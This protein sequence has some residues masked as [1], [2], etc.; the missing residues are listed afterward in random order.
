MKKLFV[1][2]TILC[3]GLSAFAE[4]FLLDCGDTLR[5]SQISERALR[6][7][8]VPKG[9]DGLSSAL[10]DKYFYN[11]GTKEC[12][13]APGHIKYVFD[14]E[15]NNISFYSDEGNL[16][17]E[18]V[19]VGGNSAV[20]VSPDETM[21]M[22]TGQF[23]DGNVNIK[24][25]TRRLTQ[26]NTQISVPMVVS[27]AGY[28]ILWNNCGM[29]EF[30]P[31]S[32]TLVLVD[33]GATGD[34]ET[35]N[36]T[37]TVG[38]IKEERHYGFFGGEIDVPETGEYAI[39]LDVGQ[40]MARKHN[41]SI[42][43]KIVMDA[44][45]LWLPPTNAAI[46]S[47]EKGK[48]NIVVKGEKNDKP[49][50]SYRKLD[51]TTAFRSENGVVDYTIIAGTPDEVIA[52]FRHLTGEVPMMPKWAFGYVHCRERFTSQNDLLENATEFRRRGIPIDMIVQDWQWWGNNGWN[53][54]KFDEVNYPDPKAMAD[55]LHNMDMHAMLSVWAKV[56]KNSVLG[57]E[58]E[59]K[60][61][62]IPGTD[63][64]D[65]FNN[66]AA[67]AYWQAYRENLVPTGIDGWWQDATE[68][69]ND[70]LQNRVVDNGRL[71]GNLVR[72][73]FPIVVND[74]VFKGLQE[75]RPGQRTMILT[76]CGAPGIQRY[77]VTTWSG[78]VG[79]DYNTL[80][81]QIAGGLGQMAAGLPWW[82]YDAGGFFRPGDQYSNADYQ[83]R[84]LRWIQASAFLP[85]M[86]VHG[87]MSMTEPWR[88][89]DATRENF[90]ESIKLRY[91]LLPYIYSEA[92]RVSREG[93]TLMR[94]MMF[95]GKNEAAETTQ[96]MLGDNLL[97][98][99]VY[100]NDN[101]QYILPARDGG[102]YDFFTGD[103]APSGEYKGKAP[104]SHVPA[105]VKGGSILPLFEGNPQSVADIDRSNQLTLMV[106][107]GAD[108]K[109]NL[110][111]DDGATLNYAKGEYS[112]IPIAWNDKK[113]TLTIGAKKGAYEGYKT[114]LTVK[115]PDG[116][117]KKVKYS[118]KEIK[119][120]F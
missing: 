56:D 70:D 14:R 101:C 108:A 117:S 90:T 92:S 63:W 53:A 85:M 13:K 103:K 97:V 111:D 62:Y 2:S 99:P 23:Q 119:V 24:G 83:K 33:D 20:F 3:F 5:I 18:Q 54:M 76:R 109:F 40:R 37:S 48:H 112:L 52:D 19:G 61:Y 50:I 73:V 106:Y 41:L 65:F 36:A 81:G 60:G 75:E 11:G 86:R 42:D 12:D 9:S 45:N 1:V 91:K 98:C 95:E 69:E 66:D 59:P 16:L 102:W 4:N 96:F 116:T 43:G 110:Y 10:A 77:G 87:Y 93:Y 57:K 115:L 7:Q 71:D 51:G 58:L 22:G 17:A 113:Q 31:A 82:T 105:F 120:K 29:T 84:M 72:N 68:P 80:R 100:D 47:L 67:E 35:V 79:N 104:E 107:P 38:N 27:D 118:G 55:S 6:V 89:S 114:D 30:N 78:D 44:N 34:V 88:Y 64:I 15:N 94:P 74:R 25:L 26:V 21:M 28:G 8:V 39:L 32:Q 46:V 49:T